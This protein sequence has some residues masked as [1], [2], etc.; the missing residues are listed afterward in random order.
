[1]DGL[2]GEQEQ[3]DRCLVRNWIWVCFFQSSW[4]PGAVGLKRETKETQQ[5]EEK[6]P[7]PIKRS[8]CYCGDH[9][10]SVRKEVNQKWTKPK[11]DLESLF[12]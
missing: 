4:N 5:K 8:A 6:K 11:E 1:M 10:V 3:K 2:L 9:A 7:A 12:L